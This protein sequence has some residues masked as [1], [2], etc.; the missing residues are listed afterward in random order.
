MLTPI[1]ESRWVYA[2]QQAP[3]PT[4]LWWNSILCWHPSWYPLATCL[5]LHSLEEKFS[6]LRPEMYSLQPWPST[7]CDMSNCFLASVTCLC[8]HSRTVLR[9]PWLP[10]LGRA[11][12]PQLAFA[13]SQPLL[14]ALAFK[15]PSLPLTSSS[16]LKFGSEIVVL[17]AVINKPFSYNC[18]ESEFFLWWS[19]TPQHSSCPETTSRATGDGPGEGP[20][21]FMK[22]VTI[23]S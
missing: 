12:Q 17:L 14:V 19:W 2:S 15:S 9:S 11:E 20:R 22:I 7:C 6:D 18:I 21:T 23:P 10:D 3:S 4:H 5:W 1:R 13:D 8:R 16:N